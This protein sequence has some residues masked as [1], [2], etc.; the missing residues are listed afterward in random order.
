MELMYLE[1]K[2]AEI[3]REKDIKMTPMI[4]AWATE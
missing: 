2:C 3:V 4:F 1:I